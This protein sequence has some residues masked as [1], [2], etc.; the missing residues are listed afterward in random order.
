MSSKASD[1]LLNKCVEEHGKKTASGSTWFL[2]RL[3]VDVFCISHTL[4]ENSSAL[5]AVF[6]Y[7]FCC[8]FMVVKYTP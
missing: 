5:I 6:T 4:W 3:S 7:T 1:S 8:C 2:V